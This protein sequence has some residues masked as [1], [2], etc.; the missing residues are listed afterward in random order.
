M[1]PFIILFSFVLDFITKKYAQTFLD[2]TYFII[3]DFLYLEFVKNPWI[4]FSVPVHWLLLKVITI[5]LIIS[6]A[7]YYIYHET[8]SL[9]HKIWYALL[10]WWALGNAYER[11]IYWSVTDFIGLKYFS[12]FNFA[13]VCIFLWVFILI[14][15]S[16]A[17]WRS[18]S[19]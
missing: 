15:K 18:S 9:F 7:Y 3:G 5:V 14:I 8:K 1:F 2:Q 19:N 10:L 11:I 12:I 16:Y 4:A 17:K 6:I 13:D